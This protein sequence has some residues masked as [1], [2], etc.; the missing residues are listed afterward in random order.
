MNFWNNY[1]IDIVFTSLTFQVSHHPPVSAL[2][3]THVEENIDV[4]WVQHF[5][6]KFRGML[7]YLL[8]TCTTPKLS[9]NQ[10]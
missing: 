8:F 6:P 4:M 5:I 1:E 7:N 9:Q 10:V 3:A 2:Q